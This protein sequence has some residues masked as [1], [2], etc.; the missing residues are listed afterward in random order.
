LNDSS[1]FSADTSTY[2][3]QVILSPT[4]NTLISGT[5]AWT[6]D[7]PVG[8]SVNVQVCKLSFSLLLLRL[9]TDDHPLNVSRHNQWSDLSIHASEHGSTRRTGQFM[10]GSQC[11]SKYS[12]YHFLRL[13]SQRLLR[14]RFVS[15]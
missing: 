4:Y 8:L 11:R 6:V 3:E 12:K 10:F 2:L 1:F 15:K 5:F 9:V 13:K 7:M 14:L